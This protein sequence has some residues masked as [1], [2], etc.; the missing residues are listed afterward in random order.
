[1]DINNI[2]LHYPNQPPC[3]ITDGK[4]AESKEWKPQTD[5][6]NTS[7]IRAL[8][9]TGAPICAISV[10]LAKS[11]N[12]TSPGN[13]VVGGFG[14]HGKEAPYYYIDLTLPD[15]RKL[16]NIPA[17]EYDGNDL[18]N[19]IIGMNVITMGSFNLEPE[20]NGTRFSFTL[21]K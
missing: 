3:I 17:V 5:V 4:I 20:Q 14:G 13:L 8:W 18:H 19:F 6:Y 12:M 7:Q 10:K 16:Y 15:D 11:L 21:K 1:M 2:I 9:D